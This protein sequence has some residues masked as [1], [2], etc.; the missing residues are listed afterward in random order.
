MAVGLGDADTDGFGEALGFG[1]ALADGEGLAVGEGL[2]LGDALGSGK[3][4]GGSTLKRSTLT[5]TPA[6]L[7]FGIL[8]KKYGPTKA[9]LALVPRSF[10]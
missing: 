8:D 3:T 1:L 4:I 9:A 10:S 5:L 7:P 2:T 6:A